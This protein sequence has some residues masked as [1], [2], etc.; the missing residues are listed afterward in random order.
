MALREIRLEGD[1]ILNKVARPVVKM[2][3]RM[4]TLIDDMFETM[5]EGD[6]IG[7]AAP[8]VGILRRI[9]V[10][11]CADVEHGDEPDPLVFINPEIIET[12]GEQKGS[13]GCLSVPGKVANVTR[14]NYVKLR[15]YDRDMRLFEMEA[16]EIL[17]RA[18]LHENDHLDGHLYPEIAEGALMDVDDILEEQDED[19][20]EEAE[21]RIVI[22]KKMR[23]LDS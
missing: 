22:K 9:F 17:A 8:Q 2:S 14:P 5:Y 20:Q 19:E 16:E 11:D 21:S 7:L 12:S 10:I 6:G 3:E 4:S 23:Y 15:A 13:E 1:P 18:I